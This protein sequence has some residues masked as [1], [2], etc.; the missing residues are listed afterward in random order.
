MHRSKLK[1]FIRALGITALVIVAIYI[2]IIIIGS[3]DMPK[4]KYDPPAE[5]LIYYSENPKWNYSVAL[6]YTSSKLLFANFSID[7]KGNWSGTINKYDIDGYYKTLLCDSVYV[8]ERYLPIPII[9]SEGTKIVD[10]TLTCSE[11]GAYYSRNEISVGDVLRE[12]IYYSDQELTFQGKR[13]PAVSSLPKK[14]SK[15]YSALLSRLA[16]SPAYSLS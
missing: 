9:T 11:T 1:K 12:T 5:T 6:L 3:I 4:R 15:M 2:S 13:L 14:I 7:E 10:A 16:Q 8:L